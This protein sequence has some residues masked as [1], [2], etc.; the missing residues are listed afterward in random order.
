MAIIL[1]TQIN[2]AFGSGTSDQNYF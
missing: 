1:E 2:S